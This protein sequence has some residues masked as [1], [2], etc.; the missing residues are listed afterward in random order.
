MR[1][2]R[3]RLYV[4]AS[5]AGLYPSA[6]ISAGQSAIDWR[7]TAQNRRTR[8]V[9]LD[10]NPFPRPE[11]TRSMPNRSACTPGPRVPTSSN[12]YAF[13]AVNFARLALRFLFLIIRICA[14]VVSPDRDR[15]RRLA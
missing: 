5:L 13:G 7:R 15:T 8:G 4:L 11:R 14:S 6:A 3:R 2:V 10:M 12:S 9:I 1:L